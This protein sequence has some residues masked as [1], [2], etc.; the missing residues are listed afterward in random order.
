MIDVKEKIEDLK[1]K[2]A[3]LRIG[4]ENIHTKVHYVINLKENRYDYVSPSS[5]AVLGFTSDEVRSLGLAKMEGRL[6][7]DD[8][9]RLNA[10]FD[11]NSTDKDL[12]MEVEYRF[13]HK[14]GSYIRVRENRCVVYDEY[15][16]PAAIV[17]KIQEK[18][19]E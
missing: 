4:V 17:G 8:R 3:L 18:A 14:N 7:Q 5:L 12:A 16:E 13:Q 9:Q 10:D 6:H 15:G 19:G 1:I 2:E 11:N